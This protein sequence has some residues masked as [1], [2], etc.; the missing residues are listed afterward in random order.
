LQGI[1]AARRVARRFMLAVVSYRV[2]LAFRAR[3]AEFG[4]CG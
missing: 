3:T 2:N 4:L 1:L